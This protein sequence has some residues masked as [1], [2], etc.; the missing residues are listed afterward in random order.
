MYNFSLPELC[1]D[2]VLGHSMLLSMNVPAV[3]FRYSSVC[4][5]QDPAFHGFV[6]HSSLC[7]TFL[8]HRAWRIGPVLPIYKKRRTNQLVNCLESGMMDNG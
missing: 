6:G 8:S 4:L 7:R 2:G 3:L 5:E 1:F